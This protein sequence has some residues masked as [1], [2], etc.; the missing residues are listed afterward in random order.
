[1]LLCPSLRL[2]LALGQERGR[3][4]QDIRAAEALVA[5]LVVVVVVMVLVV[6]VVMV[7]GVVVVD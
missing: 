5:D 2:S 6:A 4:E 3:G 1:M 7:M